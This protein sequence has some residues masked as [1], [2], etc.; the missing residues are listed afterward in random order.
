MQANGDTPFR[1]YPSDGYAL[2]ITESGHGVVQGIDDRQNEVALPD[3]HAVRQNKTVLQAVA[4]LVA[5]YEQ[6]ARLDSSHGK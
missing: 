2:P 6:Q 5:S 3:L 1:M 4:Q